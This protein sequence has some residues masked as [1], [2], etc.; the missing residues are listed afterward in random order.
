MKRLYLYSI[1]IVPAL[2]LSSCSGHL[3]LSRLLGGGSSAAG[4]PAVKA[5][6]TP[7]ADASS[8]LIAN[9]HYR[10]KNLTVKSGTTLTWTNNDS[11]PQ[12]VTSD[13]PGV[14]DSGP[15][16]PGATFVYTFA[17]AGVFPYHSTTASAVYGAIT[18][19]P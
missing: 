18:V 6:H 10:P 2:L 1:V 16:S 4:T 13:T 11:A 7:S 12:S 3:G 19:T 5:T 14:F 9:G 15:I 8:I 17:K